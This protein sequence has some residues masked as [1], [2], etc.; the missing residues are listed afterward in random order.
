MAARLWRFFMSGQVRD[1]APIL[2]LTWG[3]LSAR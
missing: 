1:L 2:A 3:N